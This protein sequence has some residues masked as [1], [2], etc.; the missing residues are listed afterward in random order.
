MNNNNK[1]MEPASKWR[2]DRSKQLLFA[3][4]EVINTG[5]KQ[6]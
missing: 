2:S 4:S 6:G 3:V 1:P 5:F